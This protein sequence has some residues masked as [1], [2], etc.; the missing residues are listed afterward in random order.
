MW[1]DGFMTSSEPAV[2]HFT[3]SVMPGFWQVTGVALW[4]PEKK[5]LQITLFFVSMPSPCKVV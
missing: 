5:W 1:S 4:L 3:L 2:C